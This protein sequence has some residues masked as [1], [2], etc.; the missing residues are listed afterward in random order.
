MQSYHVQFLQKLQEDDFQQII[1]FCVWSKRKI[2]EQVD[3]FD[4]VWFGDEATYIETKLPIHTI[5]IAIFLE[6]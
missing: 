3:L 2:N 5:F 4:L 1:D 6:P